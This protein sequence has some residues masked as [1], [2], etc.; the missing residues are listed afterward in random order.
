MQ[1][2]RIAARAPAP[3]TAVQATTISAE[4]RMSVGNTFG[5]GFVTHLRRRAAQQQAS[6]TL[7]RAAQ[8]SLAEQVQAW[9]CGL[10]EHARKHAYTLAELR[11]VFLVGP[12]KLGPALH[13][14]GFRRARDWRGNG[15]N[16]RFW[17]PPRL[18]PDDAQGCAPESAKGARRSEPAPSVDA[19]S[20]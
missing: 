2:A 14:A 15:P 1:G 9:W 11:A 20:D 7:E 19:A 13:E 6:R 18:S 5:G 17:I 3:S 16:R 10:P 8:P 12:A 4:D